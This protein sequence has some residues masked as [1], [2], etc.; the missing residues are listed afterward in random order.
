MRFDVFPKQTQIH[1]S[2]CGAVQDKLPRISALRHMMRNF[3]CYHPG[4]S[5][6]VFHPLEE[7][8][9]PKMRNLRPELTHQQHTPAKARRR[10]CT[11]AP[12]Q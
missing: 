12:V 11:S 7:G 2:I 8:L 10:Q 1:F 9:P 6:H 4:K 3:R 5:C